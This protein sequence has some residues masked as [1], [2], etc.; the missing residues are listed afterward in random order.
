MKAA[1]I[2]KHY[3]I[4]CTPDE[5][6]E[7]VIGYGAYIREY[8]VPDLAV[9]VFQALREAFTEELG[10]PPGDPITEPADGDQLQP[11]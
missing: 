3:N 10:S 2:P 6:R 5:M 8:E 4:N 11:G 1:Q 7:L 9:E